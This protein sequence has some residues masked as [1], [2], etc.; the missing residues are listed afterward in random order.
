MPGEEEL[1]L[2]REVLDPGG[3]RDAEVSPS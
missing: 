2:I 1:R 3:R